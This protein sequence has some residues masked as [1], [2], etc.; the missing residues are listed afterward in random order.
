[1]KRDDTINITS[2]YAQRKG[3]VAFE[4]IRGKDNTRVDS[5]LYQERGNIS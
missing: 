2:C 1:M 5:H 4:K 3:A